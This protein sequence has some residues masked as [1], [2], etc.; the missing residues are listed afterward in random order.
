MKTEI[1]GVKLEQQSIGAYRGTVNGVEVGYTA[2]RKKYGSLPAYSVF[3]DNKYY[4]Y[5]SKED[6]IEAIVSGK[7]GSKTMSSRYPIT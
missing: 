4:M 6:A 5:R 2:G 3:L 7:V 1:M